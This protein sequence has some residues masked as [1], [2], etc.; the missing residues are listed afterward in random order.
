MNTKHSMSADLPETSLATQIYVNVYNEA[1]KRS[2]EP[3]MPTQSGLGKL[4]ADWICAA[5][6]VLGWTGIFA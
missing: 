4:L 2:L 6:E 3:P 5:A 1:L